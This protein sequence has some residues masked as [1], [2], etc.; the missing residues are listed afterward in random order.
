[1]TDAE[2]IALL[3][4]GLLAAR[5][6]GPTADYLGG[7]IK[8]WTER[9]TNNLAAVFGN[10]ARKLGDRLDDPGGVPPRVLKGILEEG[11]FAEDELTAEYLGGVLASSRTSSARDDRGTSLIALV[12][13]LSTYALRTHYLMYAAARPHLMG[14]AANLGLQNTRKAE[15]FF[16]P[17]DAL[18]PGLDLSGNEVSD[19]PGILNHAVHTLIREGLIE[20]DFAIA[21][22]PR[23]REKY[24][25]DLTAGVVYALSPIGIELFCNA[26]G[27]R[28]NYLERFK[29][30]T[31]PLAIDVVIDMGPGGQRMRDVGPYA[32]PVPPAAA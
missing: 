17:Y 18:V 13:R 5:V 31:A 10:A 29:D 21:A 16:L 12:G 20:D 19:L 24:R 27:L 30:S 14:S 9:G 1:M 32:P 4:P 3:G 11:Q 26:H 15:K 8:N 25:K 23:M 2:L 7:G 22:A 6:L 28:G